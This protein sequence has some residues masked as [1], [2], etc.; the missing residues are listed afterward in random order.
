MAADTEQ[1]EFSVLEVLPL[2]L[3]VFEAD[4]RVV[5]ASPQARENSVCSVSVF[6][7]RPHSSRLTP[8]FYL[9]QSVANFFFSFSVISE[10]CLKIIPQRVAICQHGS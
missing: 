9:S 6:R 3:V 8:S 2:A 5:W 10:I 1:T 7:P 4:G